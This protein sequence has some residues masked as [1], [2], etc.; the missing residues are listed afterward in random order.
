M[1]TAI[2]ALLVFSLECDSL[3]RTLLRLKPDQA[4]GLTSYAIYLWQ[5]LFTA[6]ISSY[7]NSGKVIA[8]L[9][10]ILMFIVPSS[11]FFI[12]MPAMKLGKSLAGRVR[13]QTGREALT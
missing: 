6:P 3:L 5:E 4:V 7:I 10:P 1:P 9:L 8:L 12:E 11:W 13:T 2:A